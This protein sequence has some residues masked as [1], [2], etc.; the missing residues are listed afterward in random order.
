LSGEAGAATAVTN[1]F[2]GRPARGIVNRLMREL[3]PMNTAAPDF[4]LAASALAP[5]RAHLESLGCGDFSPLWAGENT[6]TCRERPAAE[7]TRELLRA[8][9][10][11]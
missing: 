4:P 2:T 8:F 3:G 7:V 11:T 6:R 9:A 5:L 10:D 1:L